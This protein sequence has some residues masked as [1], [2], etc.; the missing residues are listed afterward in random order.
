MLKT[1][2]TTVIQMQRVTTT[3]VVS[4][5]AVTKDSDKLVMAMLMNVVIDECDALI[6]AQNCDENVTYCDTIGGCTC[7][8]K[9]GW[10]TGGNGHEGVHAIMST[11]AQKMLTHTPVTPTQNVSI[12]K[13]YD[14][15]C[16]PSFHLSEGECVDD[17]ECTNN[18]NDYHES[19]S[20]CT[21]EAKTYT[22][23]WVTQWCCQKHNERTRIQLCLHCRLLQ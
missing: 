17:H 1:R 2:P 15:K 12:I 19:R 20:V 21:N 23:E 4:Y 6:Q 16:L 7:A 9:T 22:M 11:N 5:A 8:C 18:N 10:N 13:V 14:C 3:Q